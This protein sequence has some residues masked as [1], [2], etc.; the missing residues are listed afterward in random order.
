MIE[1]S[2]GFILG[3]IMTCCILSGKEDKKWLLISF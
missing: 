2:L 1:F 3:V